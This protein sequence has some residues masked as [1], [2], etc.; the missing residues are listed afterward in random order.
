MIRPDEIAQAV[1]LLLRLG[2]LLLEIAHALLEIGHRV[3]H[4]VVIGNDDEVVAGLAVPLDDPLG[5][6]ST[7][8]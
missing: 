7:V 4:A 1:L 6:R 8:T 5:A 2:T 3:G